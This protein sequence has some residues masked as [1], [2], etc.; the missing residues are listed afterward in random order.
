MLDPISLYDVF[1][2]FA[3][4]SSSLTSHQLANTVAIRMEMKH[5]YLNSPPPKSPRYGVDGADFDLVEYGKHVS[6]TTLSF[7]AIPLNR[8]LVHHH[9][10]R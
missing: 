5:S 3:C 7:N 8:C 1:S 4:S 6:D 9:S 10:A 2:S